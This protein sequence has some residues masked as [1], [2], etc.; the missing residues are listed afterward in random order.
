MAEPTPTC[1]ATID[2][3]RALEHPTL[4]VPY[5]TLNKKFRIAQ[6]NIDREVSHVQTV[7]GDLEKVL[8]QRGPCVGDVAKLLDNVV[9]KLGVLKRK[10]DENI[11]DELEAAKICKKRVDH[12]KDYANPQAN[13]AQQWRR[14]RLDRM[15]VEYFLRA[16]FY[17][18]ALKLAKHSDIQDFT[19]IDLFVAAKEVEDSLSSHETSKCLAW[20]YENRSKLRRIKSSLEFNLRQQEFIEM[21]KKEQR[22][23]AVH[24]ARKYFTAAEP[25]QMEDIQKVMALLAFPSNTNLPTY[26]KLL[27]EKQWDHL[28]EQFR[29]ENYKIHQLNSYSVFQVCLQA[30]LSALKTPNCY[31]K[32]D[33]KRNSDCPVCTVPLNTLAVP[34]PNAHSSHS[35]LICSISGEPMNECNPPLMFPNGYCYGQNAIQLNCAENNGKFV[36]PSTGDAYQMDQ[37]EKV[38]VM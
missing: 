37:A 33:E 32:G 9:D 38:Y 27:D 31:S 36:C 15:L 13:I 20:C 16:G 7:T 35:R 19:N 6:K 11:C 29:Q 28:I 12:L 24:H 30:G 17:Q 26:S 8:L 10:S 1:K 3:L 5:E 25:D 2:E 34:L 22:L 18:T 21:I 23:E 4:K 14:R